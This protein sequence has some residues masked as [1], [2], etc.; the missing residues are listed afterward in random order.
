V[1]ARRAKPLAQPP[2]D[3][4][5]IRRLMDGKLSESDWQ[6]QVEAALTRNGWWFLH[7]PPNVVVCNRCHAKIYRGIQKGF[8]DIFAI[9][10]PR[11][12]WLELKR[13]RGQLEPEQQQLGEM[14]QACGQT[15]LHARP[16]DRAELLDLIAHPER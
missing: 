11:M 10:P 14:L 16:R 15:W 8:P 6:K 4:P 2:L 3:G 13:E 7:I 5:A 12:L 1:V 9:K